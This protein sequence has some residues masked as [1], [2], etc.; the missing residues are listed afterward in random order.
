[1]EPEVVLVERWQSLLTC[2]NEVA[3][4]LERALQDTHG[5]T[6]S[7][8]ETLDRLTTQEC[9][10]RRMQDLAD[11]MYLSQSALSRTVSRLVK[12][13]LAERTHCEVDRR[14]VFVAITTAGRARWAEARKTQLAV[15]AEHLSPANA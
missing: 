5:L 13:G 8:Y 7:E 10:K 4:H 9:D 14:G 1:M 6:L 2:Y 11:T 12:E 15:L 3:C